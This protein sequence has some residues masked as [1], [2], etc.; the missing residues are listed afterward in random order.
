M[1][2]AMFESIITATKIELIHYIVNIHYIVESYICDY[3]HI[4]FI[5]DMRDV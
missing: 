2:K 4:I 3:H 5:C 1:I